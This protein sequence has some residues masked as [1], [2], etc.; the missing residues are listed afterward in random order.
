MRGA[1]GGRAFRVR[2]RSVRCSVL[3]HRARRYRS[4][5][6][7]ARRVGGV[8]GRRA[9]VGPEPRCAR[10]S[11]PTA[12]R[13]GAKARPGSRTAPPLRPG[14]ERRLASSCVRAPAHGD[15]SRR[16]ARS[17][18]C[19]PTQSPPRAAAPGTVSLPSRR[20]P[21]GLRSGSCVQEAP[22]PP[23]GGAR[24]PPSPRGGPPCPQAQT[25][26]SGARVPVAADTL[27]AVA[28]PPCFAGGAEVWS[29]AAPPYGR[30]TPR[31]APEVGCSLHHPQ[32]R[33]DL[34]TAAHTD[35]L[36][37]VRRAG[38]ARDPRP[39]GLRPS[40][41]PSGAGKEGSGR[42]H[43]GP[44]RGGA[45]PARLLAAGAEGSRHGPGGAQRRRKSLGQTRH[46]RWLCGCALSGSDRVIPKP[47]LS[48]GRILP[49]CRP[50][51]PGCTGRWWRR[52]G[53]A[54]RG[55]K[56]AAASPQP[57]PRSPTARAQEASRYL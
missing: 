56:W 45:V 25:G 28:A 42:P 51:A 1:E 54:V 50:S 26:S 36:L 44:A 4:A 55:P 29:C 21:A 33:G 17:L 6:T 7:A 22:K 48:K 11:A 53:A 57:G 35:Q 30:T 15:G 9:T 27:G 37:T 3:R 10:G 5:G 12:G 23:R 49:S 52:A 38:A 40:E 18:L 2:P 31:A 32:P 34:R 41:P 14:G 20:G 39:G 13:R 8:V 16:A 47:S 43:R 24:T 19:R 46:P